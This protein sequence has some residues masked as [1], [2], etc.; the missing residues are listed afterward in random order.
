MLK[1]VFLETSKIRVNHV[2]KIRS[3]KPE[4]KAL[5]KIKER[6]KQPE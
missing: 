1:L 2:T 3:A 5:L 4:E 6:K